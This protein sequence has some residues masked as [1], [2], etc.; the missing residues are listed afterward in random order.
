MNLAQLSERLLKGASFAGHILGMKEMAD[1]AA[2][3]FGAVGL[4][5]GSKAPKGF[6]EE[7]GFLSLLTDVDTNENGKSN[8]YRI[9]IL[10][11]LAYFFMPPPNTGLLGKREY[12]NALQL[13]MRFVLAIPVDTNDPKKVSP[14]AWL[15]TLAKELHK[16]GDALRQDGY[17][18]IRLE[19]AILRVPYPPEMNFDQ[20]VDHMYQRSMERR[21]KKGLLH[22]IVRDYL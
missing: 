16:G 9:L 5:G 7:L 21:A 2:E 12:A 3:F 13:F 18:R 22:R 19:H 8:G 20:K 10:A 11:Y 14:K 15:T 6:E 17:K 1:Q 4:P